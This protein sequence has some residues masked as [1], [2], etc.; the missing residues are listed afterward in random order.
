[1]AGEHC[2]RD[3]PQ[4]DMDDP[5]AVFPGDAVDFR[6]GDVAAVVGEGFAGAVEEHEVQPCVERVLVRC[7]DFDQGL[8]DHVEEGLGVLVGC[9]MDVCRAVQG[10]QGEFALEQPDVGVEGNIRYGI[11]VHPGA[12]SGPGQVGIDPACV[13]DP[14]LQDVGLLGHAG[15]VDGRV[16]HPQLAATIF[17]DMNIAAGPVAHRGPDVDAVGQ[18]GLEGRGPGFFGIGRI[19]P[20]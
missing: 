3:A 19:G 4:G 2:F 10:D 7:L 16:G 1:M 6:A 17:P 5:D 9:V 12:A 18:S 11:L 20:A 8:N 13:A 14:P 15:P